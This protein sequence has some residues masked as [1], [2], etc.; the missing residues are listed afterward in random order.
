MFK[1]YSYLTLLLLLLI[2][3]SPEKRLARLIEH[4]PQLKVADTLII[5]DTI[6]IPLIQ[7]DT[8]LHIDSL[9]DTVVIEKERLQVSIL[10]LHDTLYL[11]GKCKADTIFLEKKIPV[12]KI[13]TVKPD[14]FNQLISRLPWLIVGLIAVVLL[15]IFLFIR[16][17]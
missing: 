5:R 3:C 8:V 16:F 7:A 2:S 17:R 11:Q 9:Y 1:R 6:P 10:R 12:E 14:R 4:H 13:I 15:I